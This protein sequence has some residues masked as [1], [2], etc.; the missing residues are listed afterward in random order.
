MESNYILVTSFPSTEQINWT[1]SYPD[2]DTQ[3]SSWKAHNY[4]DRALDS[5][6]SIEN[7]AIKIMYSYIN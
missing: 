2:I 3:S 6:P 7:Y 1:L 5:L 4:T